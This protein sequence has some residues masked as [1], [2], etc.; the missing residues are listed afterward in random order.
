[1]LRNA[2]PDSSHNL[3]APKRLLT[4][5]ENRDENETMF[6]EMRHTRDVCG[7]MPKVLTF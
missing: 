1:M 3:H 4:A 2:F 6:R 5:T 7:W